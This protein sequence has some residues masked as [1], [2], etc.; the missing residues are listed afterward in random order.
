MKTKEFAGRVALVTGASSG[1]GAAVAL[2]FG[3]AG[4][5]VAVHYHTGRARAEKLAAMIPEAVAIG[6]DVTDPAA[7]NA[8]A[9]AVLA[10]WGRI[11]ILVN[12]AGQWME[13]H[14]LAE[15]PPELWHAMI[16][17]NLNSVFYACQ[18]VLP[19]MLRQG[20]GSIVNI[21]SVA[22]HTGGAGGTVPYGAAKAGVHV[23]T[24]GLAREL[25]A[26]GI[27]VNCVAPGIIDTPMQQRLSGA[28]KLAEW[29]RSV[30][31]KRVGVAEDVVGAVLFLAS[32]AASYLT[33][34]II[35]VNGGLLMH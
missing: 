28:E 9:E 13:K 26:A 3:A 4:A 2:A 32:D 15:C 8:L 6:A 10:R 35:E 33:G 18:A 22:G 23:L 16:D 25:A 19:A 31:L 11:D 17:V 24:R 29:S 1:I 12:N 20:S 34:E 27:R 5:C 30:P 21:G 14:P 7:V